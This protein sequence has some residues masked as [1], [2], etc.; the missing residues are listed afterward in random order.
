MRMKR[1][2]T[3]ETTA[4]T[5]ASLFVNCAP[6]AHS[7]PGTYCIFESIFVVKP[8]VSRLYEAVIARECADT[9]LSAIVSEYGGLLTP[10]MD[11]EAAHN[12]RVQLT[13]K[14]EDA[15]G[16]APIDRLNNVR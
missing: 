6:V 2:K 12:K 1:A 4:Q 7:T 10:L 5:T 11:E 8:T 16:C 3:A 14:I 9:S 15:R 13:H